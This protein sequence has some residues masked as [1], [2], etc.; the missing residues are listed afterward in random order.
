MTRVH[1]PLELPEH[2]SDSVVAVLII[3]V[4]T[5]GAF[6][7]FLEAQADD[8]ESSADRNARVAMLEASSAKLDRAGSA[9]I[10][11]LVQ[12]RGEAWKAAADA[13]RRVERG[14]T[15]NFARVHEAAARSAADATARDQTLTQA[16]REDALAQKA[17]AQEELAR[18]FERER[19]AHTSQVTRFV[20]V[21]TDFAVALLLLGLI[22]RIPYGRRKYFIAL[23][24]A[25]AVIT[26]AWAIYIM[27]DT[28]PGPNRAVIARYA[29]GRAALD[30]G[31]SSVTSLLFHQSVEQSLGHFT[32]ALSA[33][34]KYVPALIYRGDAHLALASDPPAGKLAR[35]EYVAAGSD[36][37]RATEL[38]RNNFQAWNDLA[39]SYW[40]LGRYPDA[41]EAIEHAAEHHADE[42]TVAFNLLEGIAAVHGRQN[43]E[44]AVQLQA[45]RDVL[46]DMGRDAAT[47]LQYD[48]DD[49]GS[50]SGVPGMK[51]LCTDLLQI[52]TDLDLHLERTCRK[53]GEVATVSSS[54]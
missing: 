18:A 22:A 19:D 4:A 31:F 50:S 20:A 6:A 21:I 37:L 35:L 16:G 1:E 44:Y 38:D 14:Q 39:V 5:F 2:V 54:P 41:L 15:F 29:A 8:R 45:F 53:P 49:V 3:V 23:P 33:D 12:G 47:Y 13:L 28:E 42:P 17:Y 51:G 43:A 32:A 48:V 9:G 24:A 40:S 27:R 25:G 36:L 30:R 10:A 52:S 46:H 26:L 34:P 11:R 7:A